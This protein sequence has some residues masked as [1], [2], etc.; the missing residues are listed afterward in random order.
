MNCNGKFAALALGWTLALGV[1]GCAKKDE[2]TAN[3]VADAIKA[4][5]ASAYPASLGQRVEL[6]KWDQLTYDCDVMPGDVKRQ[7]CTTGG[8]ITIAGYIAGAQ[9]SEGPKDIPPEWIFTFEKRGE[10]QWAA[11]NAERKP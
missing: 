7:R 5:L 10:G 2:P 4:V 3:Q 11:V 1:A 8:T 6:Q 9:T